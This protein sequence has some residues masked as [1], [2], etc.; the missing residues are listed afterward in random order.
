MSRTKVCNFFAAATLTASIAFAA[1]GAGA[2]PVNGHYV[3]DRRGDS[4]QSQ[5][6]TAELGDD[7]IFAPINAIDYHDHRLNT[8]IVIGVPDD[9]IANDWTVH[10]TNMS[11]QAWT[12]LFFV[13][14]KG[15][16]IGNADGRVEDVIGAAGIFTDA[17][18]IDVDGINANLLSE[19]MHAD[20][21]FEPGEDWEFGVMNFDTGAVSMPPVI[22]T[23]DVFAGS[24]LLGSN[25]GVTRGNASILGIPAAVP[26]PGTVGVVTIAVTS[27]LMRRPHRN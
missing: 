1:S 24:S 16:A 13:A 9:G 18:H 21:I 10:M 25:G 7:A 11:G 17:F 6:L 12:N 27:L 4:F 14:D 2:A 20:G 23:P 26:R 3:D 5:T 19:S 8:G 22:I 15:A